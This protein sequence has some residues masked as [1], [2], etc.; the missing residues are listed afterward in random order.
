MSTRARTEALDVIVRELNLDGPDDLNI[1]PGLRGKAVRPIS[2]EEL[3][4]AKRS[5]DLTLCLVTEYA[6]EP[7]LR[8]FLDAIEWRQ[9]LECLTRRAL[10]PRAEAAMWRGMI[11]LPSIEEH[12]KYKKWSRETPEGLR[13]VETAL[14][15][16]VATV[17]ARYD[18]DDIAGA[19]DR[20]FEL[21]PRLRHH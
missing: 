12:E 19:I 15:R 10:R 16:A 17:P 9:L 14:L 2:L 8:P 21:A 11:L 13:Q 1:P 7:K 20:A 6:A 4:L 3:D 5:A 18:Q